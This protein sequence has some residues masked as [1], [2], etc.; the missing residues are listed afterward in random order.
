MSQHIIV[1]I[2]TEKLNN[3]LRRDKALKAVS[4]LERVINSDVFEKIF[5]ETLMNT[6]YSQAELSSFFKAAPKEIFDLLM[7]GKEL[8]SPEADHKMNIIIDDY[9]S[10]KRVVGF[11][12]P[13][14]PTIYVNTKYFDKRS[15]KLIGSN[16]LHEYGHLQGLK[17]DFKS[18]SRRPSSLCYL[19]NDIYE[20]AYDLYFDIDPSPNKKYCKRT[21]YTAFLKKKCWYA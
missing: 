20:K 1:N 9:Y 10:I 17:H 14:E 11:T 16:L 12:Y 2:N 19:F 5:I 21:W 15:S 6:D 4:Q 8:L 3:Q 7:S 13:S 18:T